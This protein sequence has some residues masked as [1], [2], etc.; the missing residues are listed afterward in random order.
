MDTHW[1]VLSNL[2][3]V[4]TTMTSV[5]KW[6]HFKSLSFKFKLPSPPPVQLL[7]NVPVWLE[8]QLSAL[9]PFSICKLYAHVQWKLSMQTEMRFGVLNNEFEDSVF[10]KEDVTPH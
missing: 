6:L 9:V 10:E 1:A 4:A 2:L 8:F 7:E 3:P 5:T